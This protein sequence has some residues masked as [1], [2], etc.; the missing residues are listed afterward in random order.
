MGGLG[1]SVYISLLLIGCFLPPPLALLLDFVGLTVLFVL[2]TARLF[3]L[4]LAVFMLMCLEGLAFSYTL[5]V[6]LFTAELGFT[7]C[8][9]LFIFALFMVLVAIK[10]TVYLAAKHLQQKHP[11]LKEVRS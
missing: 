6:S 11:Y 10:T 8:N 9:V 3:L 2:A 4:G 7:L 5:T 1:L